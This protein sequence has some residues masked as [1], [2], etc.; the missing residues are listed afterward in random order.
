TARTAL[1]RVHRLAP[2]DTRMT[3]NLA[4]LLATATNETVWNPARALAL[5]EPLSNAHP[6]VVEWLDAHAAARAGLGQ[7]DDAIRLALDARTRAAARGDAASVAQLDRRLATY[8]AGTPY[9]EA[10]AAP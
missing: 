5:I 1:E 9:R 3:G 2:D 4:W 7:F 8:R 6:D 10:T